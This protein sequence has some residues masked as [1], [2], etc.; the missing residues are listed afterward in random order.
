MK[1][2]AL[3]VSFADK[4]NETV[5]GMAAGPVKYSFESA[6]LLSAFQLARLCCRIGAMLLQV[7]RL[8]QLACALRQPPFRYVVS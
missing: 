2:C 6:R 3:D 4:L 1:R 5:G 8:D 7:A